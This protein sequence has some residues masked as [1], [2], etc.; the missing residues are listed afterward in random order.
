MD[1]I[2]VSNQAKGEPL[3]TKNKVL[4]AGAAAVQVIVIRY[5]TDMLEH[6]GMV[7]LG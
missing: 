1:A 5:S 2:P 3:S 4:L 7:Y 6:G